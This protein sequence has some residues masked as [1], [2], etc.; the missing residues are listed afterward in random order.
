MTNL[1][2]YGG[3][4]NVGDC[5]SSWLFDKLGIE[6]TTDKNKPI[7]VISVGSIL[8]R[9]QLSTNALV[10]GSGFHL[11]RPNENTKI[12]N[13]DNY[14]AV[15]GK[16][17]I[18]KLNELG[19]RNI[20]PTLGDPGLLVS[21][22]Y[23]KPVNVKY[24]IGIIPHYQNY[25]KL[26]ELFNVCKFN[27][28]IKLIDVRTK[29]VETFIDEIRSC[30]FILSTSLHG[31]IFSHSYGIPAIHL[32]DKEISESGEC[33]KYKDY[34]S[35]LDIEYN[36]V[37][38]NNNLEDIVSVYMTSLDTSKYIPSKLCLN[39]IQNSLLC[40]A[41]ILKERLLKPKHNAV[42]CA[43]AKNEHLY[44]NEWVKHY[45]DLGFEKIYLFDNDD[46]NFDFVGNYV[47]KEYLDKLVVFNK[48]GIHRQRFQGACYKY[49]YDKY[50]SNF[51]WCLF[52]D[53]DEFLDGVININR[54]L[55]SIPNNIE[56]VRIKWNLFGDDNI[57]ERDV[58]KPVYGFFKKINTTS[59]LKNQAKSI[60]RSG[61]KDIQFNS[62]HYAHKKYKNDKV[63]LSSC[64]PSGR[65]CKSEI[66]I[67][68]DYSKE[69]IFLNHYMTKTL[70]EFVNQ[71]VNRG[72]ACFEDRSIDLDYFWRINDKT[73]EK[74][75]WIEKNLKN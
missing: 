58:S 24:K 35:V 46:I 22:F 68:E 49:F 7:D 19:V 41:N 73:P 69:K 39:S 43:M 72:D 55:A 29:D 34:Y 59:T 4:L 54:V 38:L 70:S 50:N 25:D 36:N 17:T 2:Y 8:Q 52:C 51:N 45:I 16:L 28:S 3:N 6:H 13:P 71:K 33:M 47:D 37:S 18:Q 42:V 75:E 14:I 44:I 64:L 23:N 26:K 30:E 57:I 66:S 67:K 65:I 15:R 56:Q 1:Y 40:A 53:I 27:D 10:F 32:L 20:S 9:K 74:L 60:I 31:I 61:V 11:I 48:S 21:Y 63:M 62:V 5:Y 12:K